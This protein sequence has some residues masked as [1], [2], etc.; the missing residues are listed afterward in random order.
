MRIDTQRARAGVRPQL[1]SG[2]DGEQPC[3][4]LPGSRPSMTSSVRPVY[5]HVFDQWHAD[6]G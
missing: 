5:W 3:A 6:K 1:C 2:C 4:L